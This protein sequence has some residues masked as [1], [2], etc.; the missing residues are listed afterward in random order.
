MIVYNTTLSTEGMMCTDMLLNIHWAEAFFC[1][2]R[3]LSKTGG[4]PLRAAALEI[5]EWKEREREKELRQTMMVTTDP[6]I[7]I[8]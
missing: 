7:I 4:F 6:H 5:A 3:H 2:L 8:I 1:T